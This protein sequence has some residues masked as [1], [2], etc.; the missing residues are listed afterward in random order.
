M[1][2]W[3]P[4]HLIHPPSSLPLAV[5]SELA[6]APSSPRAAWVSH[7]WALVPAAGVECS[8]ARLTP[9]GQQRQQQGW[10]QQFFVVVAVYVQ[11]VIFSCVRCDF[12]GLVLPYPPRA[13]FPK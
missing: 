11:H 6:L 7:V 2:T 9:R 5:R 1:G 4:P 12:E 8:V 10:G 13:F 3:C